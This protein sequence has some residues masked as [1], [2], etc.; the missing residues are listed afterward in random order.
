MENRIVLYTV[1]TQL[2]YVSVHCRGVY[3]KHAEPEGMPL[4]QSININTY[5]CLPIATSR[6]SKRAI[7]AY[8]SSLLVIIKAFSSQ[9]L[10]ESTKSSIGVTESCAA[11]G[12]IGTQ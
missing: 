10:Q 11:L 6:A 9:A 4:Y 12:A 7:L 3:S 8:Y 1:Y 5:T 2:F